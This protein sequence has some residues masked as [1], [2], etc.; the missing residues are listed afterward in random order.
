LARSGAKIVHANKP[1]ALQLALAPARLAGAKIVLNLRDTPDPERKL[2]ATRFRLLF[3]AADHVLFLSQDMA[4]RW[5]RIA[6][7]AKRAFTVTYSI[8]DLQRFAPRPRAD[9]PPA[10][11]LSGIIREKK[12]QLD[13]LRQAAPALAREGIETWL[14]GDF[15]PDRNAYMQACAEAAKPLGG[16]VRFLGYRTDIPELMANASVVAVSSRHEGLVRAMIE[17]MACARPVVS[18]DVASAREMLEEQSGG[19]GTVVEA[20][21]HQAMAEAIVRYCRDEALAEQAGARGRATAER[22][23]AADPVVERYEEV[24]ERLSRV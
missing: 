16:A 8:V 2:S 13:F 20:G 6:A 10:V 15:D 18:F 3:E 19:A 24:Y 11:L 12:G 9:G 1:L 5:A 14:A 7:N 21:D 17:A 23:F 22:L 4:E